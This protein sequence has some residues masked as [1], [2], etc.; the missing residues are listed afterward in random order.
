LLGENGIWLKIVNMNCI[1]INHPEFRSLLSDTGLDTLDL[2]AQISLWMDDNGPHRF[3]TVEE[4]KAAEVGRQRKHVNPIK[5]LGMKY[6]MNQHGFMPKNAPLD[7]LQRDARKYNLKLKRARNGNYYFANQNNRKINPFYQLESEVTEGPDAELTNR[8]LAWA[9]THG[10]EVT[11]M[12]EMLDRFSSDT[13]I[14]S[15]ATALADLVN[16]VIAVADD[17]AKLDTLAEEVAHFATAI[18]KNDPSVKRAMD[19]ISETEIYEQVK[20]DYKDVYNSEEQFKKEALDKLLAEAI[21][22]NFQEDQVREEAKGFFQWLK[23]II[24][25]VLRKFKRLPKDAKTE[26]IEDLHPLAQSILAG[27]YLGDIE[28]TGPTDSIYYQFEQTETQKAE[29]KQE[30][31]TP[32]QRKIKF[33]QDSIKAFEDN[34]AIQIRRK[35]KKDKDGNVRKDIAT[36]EAKIKQIQYKLNGAKIE[37]AIEQSIET[38]VEQFRGIKIHLEKAKEAGEIDAGISDMLRD[39]SNHYQSLFKG[40]SSAFHYYKFSP[41]Q[42]AKYDESFA[43]INDTISYVH[44][45]NDDLSR[46]IVIDA[47]VSEEIFE[48]TIEEAVGWW[49]L[50]MGN[51]KYSN[52][53]VVNRALELI[54]ESKYLTRRNTQAAAVELLERQKALDSAGIKTTEFIQKDPDGKYRQTLIQEYD[55]AEYYDHKY[56]LQKKLFKEFGLDESA[57]LDT[58]L[59]T[60]EQQQKYNLEIEK[61][62]KKLLTYDPQ[63]KG[64]RPKKKSAKY[65]ELMKNPDAKAYYMAM[66]KFIKESVDKLPPNKRHPALYHQIPG[67]RPQVVE[68]LYNDN[69]ILKNISGMIKEGFLKD[70]DD[71]QFGGEARAFNNRMVPIYFTQSM[72]PGTFSTDL[73]RSTIIFYEMAENFQNMN[74]IAPQMNTVL[75]HLGN[76]EYG[77]NKKGIETNDYKAVKELIDAHIYGVAKDDIKINILGKEVSLTKGIGRL[78]SFI[79]TNNLSLNL[80]TSTA[81]FVKG[82]IDREIEDRIGLYTTYESKLWAMAEYGRQLPKVISEA[83]SKTQTS[84]LQ[85]MLQMTN[86][87]KLDHMIKNSNRN[88]LMRRVASRDM[89]FMNYHLADFSL[90]GKAMLSIMDNFR[91]YDGSFVKKADFI[92]IQT[93]KGLDPKKDKK[94]IDKLWSELRDKSFWNA[95]EE[96]EGR[97]KVKPE[98]AEHVNDAVLNRITGTVEHITH[99]LDGTLS[100]LDRGQLSRKAMGDLLLMHRGWLVNMVDTRFM[101]ENVNPLTGEREIGGIRATWD[102]LMSGVIDGYKNKNMVDALFRTG[103]QELDEHRKRGIKRTLNDLIYLAILGFIVGAVNGLADDDEEDSWWLQYS[104]YQLNRILLEQAAGNPVLNPGEFVNILDEPIAGMSTVKSLFDITDAFDSTSIK[105]GMYKDQAHWAKWWFKKTPFKHLY[106]IQFPEEKNRFIKQVVKSPTYNTFFKE[107]DENAETVDFFTQLL[108]VLPGTYN[109]EDNDEAIETIENLENEY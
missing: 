83:Y 71:T 22:A 70:E 59:L 43:E 64:K 40:F 21:V 106:E 101:K 11:A 91:L 12:Q 25:K 102:H 49:R 74:K 20:E 30:R 8:L 18:L 60:E 103:Y 67:I 51:F 54:A 92:K 87:V 104:A 99:T 84:K 24:N 1:N 44:K 108:R 89:L 95:Y 41:E 48:D 100:E 94:T 32:E 86:V 27:D 42:I 109:F 72:R 14:Q 58:R 73:T 76:R 68:R 88:A 98:F 31:A 63:I 50:N 79:R 80:V 38:A 55:W 2:Q 36:L 37:A 23:A 61:L 107:A 53:S 105:S 39:F 33:I 66:T 13:E 34:L 4:L 28:V 5:Q 65:A 97:L 85:L 46:N 93:K 82:N 10:I 19:K 57:G 15:G 81:G 35:G 56:E 75:F 90:K 69:G 17:K 47:G 77:N 96:V 7:Q 26:I 16:K 45:I 6:N 29:E 62:R 52:F 3:P 9:E 78:A